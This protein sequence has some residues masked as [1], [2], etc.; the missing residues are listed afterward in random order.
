MGTVDITLMG[1]VDIMSE[2]WFMNGL[3]CW[4]A[5]DKAIPLRVQA[6]KL[7]RSDTVTQAASAGMNAQASWLNL[8][9]FILLLIMMQ[10]TL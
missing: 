3:V 9:H 8:W 10:E 7:N 4:I 6:V 2:S 1:T 5:F